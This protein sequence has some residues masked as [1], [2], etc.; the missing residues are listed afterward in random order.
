MF[1][2]NLQVQFVDHNTLLE[3]AGSFQEVRKVIEF[4][5]STGTL[6]AL[7]PIY[8]C[9]DCD[10]KGWY[11]EIAYVREGSIWPTSPSSFEP[12]KGGPER[13]L[14]TRNIANYLANYMPG[15]GWPG[16][17]KFFRKQSTRAQRRFGKAILAEAMADIE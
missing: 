6:Q 11:E 2:N 3:M 15:S 13:T 4:L 12:E 14:R 5:G 16:Q 7:S 17:Q 8:C 9:Y 1:D 10:G